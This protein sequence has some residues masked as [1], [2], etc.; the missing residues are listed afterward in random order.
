MARRFAVVQNLIERLAFAPHLPAAM[1][2]SPSDGQRRRAP[3]AGTSL[4]RS[5]PTGTSTRGALPS[6]DLKQRRT[7]EISRMSTYPRAGERARLRAVQPDNQCVPLID[8]MRAMRAALRDV[9]DE[10]VLV[11]GPHGLEV[12]CDL[13]HRGARS[14]TL[15]RMD[16]RPE[17]QSA[18]LVVVP[19]APSLDWL[20]CVPGHA[21]RALQPAGRLV[22]RAG[23]LVGRRLAAQISRILRVHGY[24]AI[25]ARQSRVQLQLSAELPGFGRQLHA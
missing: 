25:V 3:A 2:R 20:A 14:G 7:K 16:K 19:E 18:S 1:N 23:A 15:L 13:L 17:A 9:R 21:P 6:R 22:L 12:M 11:I 10:E 5:G 24:T 4:A 8:P